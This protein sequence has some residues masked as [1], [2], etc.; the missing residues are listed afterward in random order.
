MAELYVTLSLYTQKNKQTKKTE[1]TPASWYSSSVPF[2]NHKV[3]PKR[4]K[5]KL[6]SGRTRKISLS[7]KPFMDNITFFL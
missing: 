1:L 2:L 6:S 5:N 3:T 7:I 4:R